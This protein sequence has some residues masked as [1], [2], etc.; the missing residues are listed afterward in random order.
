M[1]KTLIKYLSILIASF[2]ISAF[3]PQISLII[4]PHIKIYLFLILL[5]SGFQIDNKE[6]LGLRKDKLFITVTALIRVFMIPIIVYYCIG[7]IL[8]TFQIPLTLLVLAP[9]GI[10]ATFFTSVFGGKTSMT[11]ALTTITGILTPFWIPIFIF[12]FFKQQIELSWMNMIIEL[13]IVLILPIILSEIMQKYQ[14]KLVKKINKIQSPISLT[15]LSL[16]LIGSIS[17]QITKILKIPPLYILQITLITFI[18]FFL[19]GLVGWGISLHRSTKDEIAIV[20]SYLLMNYALTI[21]LTT[22][23]FAHVPMAVIISVLAIIPWNLSVI[24]LGNIVPWMH[25]KF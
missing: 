25:K 20:T 21:Y 15:L 10:T 9:V 17:S 13:S 18:I 3:I 4:H 8:P 11:L 22:S 6:I 24:A 23:F 16:I 2:L 14:N 1:Q 12:M 5:L 19:L 7:L